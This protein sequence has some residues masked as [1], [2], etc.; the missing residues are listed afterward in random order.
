MHDL[1]FSSYVFFMH[2]HCPNFVC[3]FTCRNLLDLWI[4]STKNKPGRSGTSNN[5][6]KSAESGFKHLTINSAIKKTEIFILGSFTNAQIQIA[7][8]Y[9]F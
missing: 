8:L 3:Q 9:N 1:I 2:T 7:I 5:P 6:T 4:S